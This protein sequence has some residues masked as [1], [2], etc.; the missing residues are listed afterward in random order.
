MFFPILQIKKLKQNKICLCRVT[1]LISGMT[2]STQLLLHSPCPNLNMIFTRGKSKKHSRQRVNHKK[3]VKL[4]G[5]T[6][7][8]NILSNSEF[9]AVLIIQVVW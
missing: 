3:K 8:I 1:C 7:Y 9:P 6:Y 4:L 5:R 2:P